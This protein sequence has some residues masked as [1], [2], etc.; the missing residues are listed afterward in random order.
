MYIRW[1]IVVAVFVHV[2]SAIVI[3]AVVD[4]MHV[5]CAFIVYTYEQYLF[6]V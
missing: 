1:C 5:T 2:V 6:T 3:V 4:C